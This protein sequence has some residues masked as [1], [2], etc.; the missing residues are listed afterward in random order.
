MF[1]KFYKT[2]DFVVDKSWPTGLSTTNTDLLQQQKSG[3]MK[4]EQSSRSPDVYEKILN[5]ITIDKRRQ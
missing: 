1:S 2:T 5:F 3:R 4:S